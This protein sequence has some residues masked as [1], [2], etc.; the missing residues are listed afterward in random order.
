MLEM[1]NFSASLNNTDF[2][3]HLD[4]LIAW[5]HKRMKFFPMMA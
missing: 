1:I 2:A 4:Q 3:E 5:I